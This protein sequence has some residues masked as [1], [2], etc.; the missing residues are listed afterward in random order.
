MNS[1]FMQI[2]GDDGTNNGSG[3]ATTLRWFETDEAVD[4]G[5]NDAPTIFAFQMNGVPTPGAVALFGLA[6]LAAT[7]R[8][9]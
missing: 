2:A 9:R 4:V 3:F 8:R 6:G 5:S 1:G 7:R